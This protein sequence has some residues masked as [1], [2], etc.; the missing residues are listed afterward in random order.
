VQ[1]ICRLRRRLSV[2]IPLRML[3]DSPTLTGFSA[4]VEALLA[5]EVTALAVVTARAT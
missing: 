3:S 2:D 4:G 5:A 1:V